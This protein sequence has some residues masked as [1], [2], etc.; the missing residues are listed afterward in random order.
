MPRDTAQHQ[1]TGD[2]ITYI[3]TPADHRR[4]LADA[5]V[6]ALRVRPQDFEYR[7][8]GFLDDR[9]TGQ[10]W[11]TELI[12]FRLYRVDDCGCANVLFGFFDRWR[13]WRAFRR[14]YAVHY[15]AALPHLHE[16]ARIRRANEAAGRG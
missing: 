7:S 1:P 16:A 8:G 6:E 9:A 3:R 5:F 14:W 10:H 11:W 15:L 2:S 4:E 12:L 13:M